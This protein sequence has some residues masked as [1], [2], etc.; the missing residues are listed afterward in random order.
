MKY[1][2]RHATPQ[3][4]NDEERKQQG[5]K[6]GHRGFC[7]LGIQIGPFAACQT[8]F[9]HKNVHFFTQPPIIT[10]FCI[11]R[12]TK[13]LEPVSENWAWK[14][15]WMAERMSIGRFQVHI[16]HGQVDVVNKLGTRRRRAQE[17]HFESFA[18]ALATHAYAL[19]MHASH[20]RETGFV[21]SI[22]NKTV[23]QCD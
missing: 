4:F 11:Q 8:D 9:V 14:L 6:M 15:P 17:P 21:F 19:R 13:R 16:Y 12:W 22:R 23:K 3:R 10:Q 20:G 5:L 1:T 18:R 2:P 7:I